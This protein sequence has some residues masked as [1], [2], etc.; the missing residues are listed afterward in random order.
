MQENWPDHDTR[1]TPFLLCQVELGLRLLERLDPNERADG[2]WVLFGGYAFGQIRGL[3]STREQEWMVACARHRLWPLRRRQAWRDALDAYRQLDAQVRAYTVPEDLGPA[4]FIG[5][6]DTATDRVKHYDRALSELPEHLGH[7]MLMAEAGPYHF[8]RWGKRTTIDIPGDLVEDM[9]VAERHPV[10]RLTAFNG[11]PVDIRRAELLDTAEWLVG[12]EYELGF[13]PIRDWVSHLRDVLFDVLEQDG[14]RYVEA[15]SFRLDGLVN[16]VGIVGAGKSTLMQLIA[17]WAARHP[18]SP[19][20]TIV[21]GDVA[22]QLRLTEYLCSVLGTAAAAPVIGFSTRGRHIQ[23]LHRRLTAQGRT[24]LIDHRGEPGFDL[25][26]T[27]CPLDALRPETKREPTRLLDAPCVGLHVPSDDEPDED[28][29]RPVRGRPRGCPLWN[30]CPRHGAAR[31]QVKA[32]IWVANMASLVTSPLSPHVSDVR[33]RQLELACLRSDIVIIDESDRVM[34]NLDEM[35]A[36]SATLAVKGPDSWLDQLHSHNIGELAREGRIQLSDGNVRRWDAS[37]GVVSTATNRLHERLIRRKDV[38]EWVGIEFFNSWTLQERL[39]NEVYPR[40]EGDDA[41]ASLDE[42]LAV[43]DFD[44]HAHARASAA[45][46]PDSTDRRTR[47]EAI[48]D[49]F[50]DDPLGDRGPYD[51][52]TDLLVASL[53]DVLHTLAP[54]RSRGKLATV[55]QALFGALP[56]PHVN[57]LVWKLEFVLLVTALHHRLNQLTHL[58]PQVEAALRLELTDNE[59]VR[60]PPLDYSPLIP[61]SPMGNLLGFQYIPDDASD[62]DQDLLTGTLRFFRCAGVGREL[63]VALPGLTADPQ[64]KRSGPHTLLMSGTSWAGTSTR[65]H[66]PETVK[67]VLRPRDERLQPVNESVF[68]TRFLYDRGVPISLSGQPRSVR[69]A[70]LKMMIEQLG[71]ERP[72]AHPILQEE[73]NEV[74]HERRRALLLV[75]SYREAEIAADQ[76]NGMGRWKGRVHVLAADDAD[77]D[78]AAPGIGDTRRLKAG[79]IR[80]GSVARFADDPNALVLVAPLLAVERGHNILN[81][82]GKAAFGVAFFLVRPHP[83]PTDL[84]LAVFAIND[85]VTRFVRGTLEKPLVP[86]TPPSFRELVSAAPSLDAAGK[87]FRDLARARWGKLLTRRYSYLRLS[88]AERRSFAWDQ[89]VTMW[90]VIGRLVRGGVPAR[91]VFVDAKFAPRLAAAGAPGATGAKRKPRD[92]PATSLLVNIKD[93]LEPFFASHGADA[94]LVRMLYAPIY[95]GLNK[96]FLQ[97]QLELARRAATEDR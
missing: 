26:S 14:S 1:A 7:T 69:P 59:L 57:E 25:L 95:H 82:V 16:A 67:L 17:V 41:A 18:R 33:L 79:S 96:M 76:L 10:D 19:H 27:A 22:E 61:E 50:R 3:V 65:A 87:A 90:Q 12:R 53:H 39:L 9:P 60:R 62:P 32:S 88:A 37:L 23:G 30:D 52:E 73:L 5:P 47:L 42:D 51:D 2:A 93:V 28:D 20:V 78:D 77:L 38:R 24:S 15:E 72:G 6:G 56:T 13:D 94:Q 36:P 84:S 45:A 89:L 54:S 11:D 71:E 70:V 63:L 91:V 43:D 21:V 75:G 35:F 55:L 4:V 29:D 49:V 31:T 44:H 48:F 58:W 85:W 92:T 66:V 97:S 64:R 80:R 68:T 83:V 74:P 8:L 81:R 86:T 34:M 46:A 40:V